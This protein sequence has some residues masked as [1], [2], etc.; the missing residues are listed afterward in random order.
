[1]SMPSMRDA[2]QL[3]VGLTWP[4]APW[5]KRRVGNEVAAAEAAVAAT[6]A[7]REV[8]ARRLRLA[9]QESIVRAQSAAE[10]AS[11]LQ[12]TVVPPAEH[13]LE[14]ARVAYLADRGEFMPVVDA[15]RV[16]LAARL[17]IRRALA[18]RDRA[19]ADLAILLGEFD[20]G[21]TP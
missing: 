8:V 21:Q 1:M 2:I 20:A 6:G 17:E 13:V 18:D 12:S 3:K 9:A 11:V 16:L 4:G 10:R 7:R 5:V 19:L 14:V 15:Q